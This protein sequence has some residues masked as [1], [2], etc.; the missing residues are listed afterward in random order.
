MRVITYCAV[1]KINTNNAC[2][3]FRWRQMHKHAGKNSVSAGYTR[4]THTHSPSS[5]NNNIFFIP[6]WC[7]DLPRDGPQI[8]GE[9]RLYQVGDVLPLNCTSGKSHPAPLVQW[10]INDEPVMT[11]I[12]HHLSATRH[13]HVCLCVGLDKT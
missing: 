12:N 1:H 10:L 2:S 7:A 5:L 9:E 11:A 13:T 8:T 4:I 3:P 6:F